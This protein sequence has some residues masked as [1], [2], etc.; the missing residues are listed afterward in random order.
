MKKNEIDDLIEQRFKKIQ[1]H[2]RNAMINFETGEISNF[3]AEIKKLKVFFHLLS[4]ES[5][6]GF[7]YRITKKMKTLYG[8]FGIIHN[9]QQQLKRTNNYVKESLAGVPVFYVNILQKELEYW[10]NLSKSFIDADY[11]FGYDKEEILVALPGKLTKISIKRFIDYIF[12]ELNTIS[13]RIDD[14]EALDAVRKFLE[15]IYYNYEI[16]V[17]FM[18]QQQINCFN[19]DSIKKCLEY[20]NDFHDKCIAI[21]LLKTFDTSGLNATEKKLLKEMENE[22]LDKKKD[23]KNKLIATLRTMNIQIDCTKTFAI[24]GITDK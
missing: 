20:F 14:D 19:Y 18:N 4:M 5:I 13:E 12:Y 3:R 9:L 16:I 2:F 10:K 24:A 7:S 17:P 22:W 21:A 11:D 1:K 23:L 8:Y 6:D 15:D